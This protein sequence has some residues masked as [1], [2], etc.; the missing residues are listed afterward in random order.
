MPMTNYAIAATMVRLFGTTALN[1]P[2]TYYIGLSTTTPTQASTSNWNFTEP[3]IGTNGYAR[4]TVV[5]NT[6]NF[7]P[8][9]VEPSS[10]YSIQN[11]VV[12][13]W[14]AASTGSWSSGANLTYAGLWD[15]A[16]G[17]NLWGYG[18]L[19]PVINVV[20]AGYTPSFAIGQI[21][22]TFT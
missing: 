16:S 8:I 18:P 11:G 20:N 6:T 2:A 9:S 14:S 12:I 21:V 7:V 13:T 17:G 15:A 10:G 5:N 22:I 1:P 4:Q 3:T 19:S